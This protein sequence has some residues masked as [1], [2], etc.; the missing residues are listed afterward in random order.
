MDRVM[1]VG[2]EKR[3]LGRFVMDGDDGHWGRAA[4]TVVM[5]RF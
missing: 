5:V 4:D 3:L 2:S 1:R